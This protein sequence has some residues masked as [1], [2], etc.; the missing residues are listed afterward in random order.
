MVF[1]HEGDAKE[2]LRCVHLGATMEHLAL[3]V[4]IFLKMDRLDLALKTV[5]RLELASPSPRI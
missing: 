5:R 4:Q 3:T 2:A 1:M